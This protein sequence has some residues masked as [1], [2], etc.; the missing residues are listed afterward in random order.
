VDEAT[1]LAAREVVEAEAIPQVQVRGKTQLLT[2]Y[3]VTGLRESRAQLPVGEPAEAA[4][5][6]GRPA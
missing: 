1:Y 6:R 2:I 4:P 5:G 3:R